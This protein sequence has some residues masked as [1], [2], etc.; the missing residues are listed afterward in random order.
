MQAVGDKTLLAQRHTKPCG[1]RN[2]ATCRA[3]PTKP[4]RQRGTKPCQL[5]GLKPCWPPRQTKPWRLTGTRPCRQRGIKPNL[6]ADSQHTATVHKVGHNSRE[7]GMIQQPVPATATAT[8]SAKTTENPVGKGGTKPYPPA[9]QATGRASTQGACSDKATTP[10]D[11]AGCH[12]TATATPTPTPA[13]TAAATATTTAC[14]SVAMYQLQ[15]PPPGFCGS[16]TLQLEPHT[17]LLLLHDPAAAAAATTTA[18]AAAAAAE[19]MLLRCCCCLRSVTTGTCP[20][21]P[22]TGGWWSPP[23]E[24]NHEFIVS[25][26]VVCTLL[27]HHARIKHGLLL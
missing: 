4:Y 13:A 12:S 20:R 11:A 10:G 24:L 26:R 2:T 18:T 17:L 23:V 16:A 6:P 8:L 27:P 5:R 22:W 21:Q 25:P 1:P 19:A 9:G 15:S 14:K 3:R 7:A